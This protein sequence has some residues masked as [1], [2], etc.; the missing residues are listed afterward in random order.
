MTEELLLKRS[1]PVTHWCECLSNQQHMRFKF[2]LDD[3]HYIQR[4]VCSSISLNII[5]SNLL[6]K[7]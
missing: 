4:R 7:F 1:L 5:T 3:T 2:L 6:N